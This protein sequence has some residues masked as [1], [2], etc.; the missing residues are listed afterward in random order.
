V[1]T[2]GERPHRE[3]VLPRARP[4]GGARLGGRGVPEHCNE[5]GCYRR[6]DDFRADFRS[7]R[8]AWGIGPRVLGHHEH[9]VAWQLTGSQMRAKP[10]F[11]ENSVA[12]VDVVFTGDLLN[13][14]PGK[15]GT[16][17]DGAFNI[18]TAGDVPA[19]VRRAWRPNGFK[20][21]DDANFD[22]VQVIQFSWKLPGY[23]GYWY[24]YV[25]SPNATSPGKDVYRFRDVDQLP[26]DPFGGGYRI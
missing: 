10:V 20:S 14:A 5:S 25:K 1:R 3:L 19:G 2:A 11:Y 26:A 21:Y 13:A 9:E 8:G 18:Y 22:H 16:P 6:Y 24:A 4:G 23:D 12:T 7:V 15:P 17:V